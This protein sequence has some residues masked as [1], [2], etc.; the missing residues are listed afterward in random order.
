MKL[1]IEARE[2]HQAKIIA[3]F[4]PNDLDKY[5]YKAARRIASRAKIPGFRPGKAPYDV[6]SRIYGEPAI[7]E[8]AIELMMEA[9]YP[10]VLAEAKIEPAAPGTLEDV[11]KGDPIKFTFIVP[12]EPAV[13]LGD[14]KE[15]RKKYSPK[16]VT[17]KQVDE[18]IQRLRRTYATAEPV[19][20][21][22][23]TGDLVYIKVDAT[24]TKTAKDEN[25]ELLKDRPLQLVIGENDPEENDYPYP[26]FGDNLIGMSANEEKKVK[27]TYPKDSKFEKLRGKA[28]EFHV[29][30]Q[31][32]KKLT[33]PELND[34]FAKMFGE[35]E[36][37]AQLKEAVKEQL[38]ARQTSEYD[39]IYYEELLDEIVKTATIKYPPQVLEHEMEHIVEN[40]THDLSHQKMELDV[41]LKTINKEKD[42]WMEEEVK[43]A[44]AKNLAKSLV[45]QE[46]SKAEEIKLANEDLQTE[47]TAM[48]TQMQQSA[49]PKA[50]S[51]QLKNKNYVNALTMEAASRV[52]NRKVFERMKDIATGKKEET[53]SETKK[54]VKTKKT[55]D[56]SKPAQTAEDAKKEVKKAKAPTGDE[57]K[58]P[59]A[60]KP[61]KVENTTEQE[62]K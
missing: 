11:D 49:D 29:L 36:T 3:E 18:F 59:A 26:G 51:K 33:L 21:P 37:F 13:I 34:E 53:P 27:Y 35:Y 44:A 1:N 32:V 50:I 23:E 15:I 31:T 28:V 61:K 38:E 2:D 25:P 4:E 6:V 43:P 47:V 55:T 41:Y 39:E 48:L 30:L 16:A 14:Y 7:E 24:I 52:M 12:L 60:K 20:R 10:E 56:P 22:A 40:V 58:L 62:K 57:P 17:D 5:K 46:L 19:E 45:M 8:D 42:A 54:N 9:V